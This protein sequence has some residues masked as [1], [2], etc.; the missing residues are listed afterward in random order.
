[1]MRR[2]SIA[3]LSSILLLLSSYASRADDRI[4]IDGKINYQNVH[5]AFDTGASKTGIWRSV[6]NRLNLKIQ[7]PPANYV[8]IAGKTI[9]GKTEKCRLELLGNILQ[10]GIMVFDLP[11]DLQPDCDGVVGWTWLIEAR[12]EMNARWGSLKAVSDSPNQAEGWLKCP[13]KTNSDILRL[14]MPVRDSPPLIMEVDTGS[15]RGICLNARLWQEWLAK[16][17]NHAVTLDS[18]YFPSVGFV[19]CKEGW[20]SEL[21]EGALNL[22]KVPVAE[23][24]PMELSI[25]GPEQCDIIIGMAALRRL[26]FVVD[27]PNQVAFLRPTK[28]FTPSRSYNYNRLGA[29]FVP[30]DAKSDDIVAAVLERTPAYEAGLRNGDVLLKIDGLE[31]EGWRTNTSV[32]ARIWAPVGT[33]LELTLRRNAETFKTKVKLRDIVTS[34]GN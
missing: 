32:L 9:A 20:A 22:T 8:P 3:I 6:A 31:V 29:A 25:G 28:Q 33:Q 13:I 34:N 30:R 23:A 4:W 15:E 7:N 18:Y 19:V 11:Y 10:T 21:H 26:D 12:Y 5:F 16:S 27:G 24:S 2:G 17:T 14:E 1:M